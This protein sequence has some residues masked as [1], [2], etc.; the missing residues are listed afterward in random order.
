[1]VEQEDRI[2]RFKKF[3]ECVKIYL[4]NLEKLFKGK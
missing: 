1:V 2:K 3:K 4:L